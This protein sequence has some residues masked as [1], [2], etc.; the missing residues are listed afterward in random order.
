MLAHDRQIEVVHPNV[1][2]GV[3]LRRFRR[4]AKDVLCKSQIGEIVAGG[5]V[6]F[7]ELL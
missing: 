5:L 1:V 2:S 7:S 4:N 3:G 6:W